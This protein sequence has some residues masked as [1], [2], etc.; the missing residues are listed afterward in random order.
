M[1]QSEWEKQVTAVKEKLKPCPFCGKKVKIEYYEVNEPVTF[2]DCGFR[3]RCYNC[4][5][6]FSR[7]L[8]CM[9]GFDIKADEAAKNW[10]VEKWNTRK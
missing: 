6:G 5:I 9:P 4:G 2:A 3:I 8:R 1:A 7:H 10:L